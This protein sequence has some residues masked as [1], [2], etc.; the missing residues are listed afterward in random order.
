[1][2]KIIL[3]L[4]CLGLSAGAGAEEGELYTWEDEDGTRHYSTKAPT[5]YEY[6]VVGDA[7]AI[8]LDPELLR[9][10]EQARAE[11]E[12]EAEAEEVEEEEE[13]DDGLTD[14]ERAQACADVG[15]QMNVYEQRLTSGESEMDDEQMQAELA[16]MQQVREQLKQHCDS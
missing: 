9:A 3:L 16:A 4:L 12:A 2:K 13:K 15:E 10:R 1:M 5:D 7:N 8:T 14:E 11:A 6:E